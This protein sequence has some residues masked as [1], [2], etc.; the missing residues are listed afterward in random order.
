MPIRTPTGSGKTDPPST[1]SVSASSHS[2][3][4]VAQWIL[5]VDI[6]ALLRPN[7]GRSEHPIPTK[8]P[9]ENS[10]ITR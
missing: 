10:L 5:E 2:A 7:H 6:R 8:E 3:K 9:V 4:A 1:F